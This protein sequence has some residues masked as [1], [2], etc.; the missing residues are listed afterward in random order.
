MSTMFNMSHTYKELPEVF[1]SEAEVREMPDPKMILFNDKLAEVLGLSAR[2][3]DFLDVLAGKGLETSPIA[4]AYA[5]HQF[6]QFT[7]LGDGRA[8]LLGEH[9]TK[10]GVRYDIQLKGTGRTEFS[11]MGDGLAPVGPMIREY[12]ISEALHA[13][14]VPTNRSLAVMTTGDTAEREASY[15]AAVLARVAS[16]HLRVG[17]FEYAARLSVEHVKS[18]ADYSIERHYPN[19]KDNE[20]KYLLFLESVAHAQSYLISEW[21]GIGFIHGVMNTDNMTISGESIDFGPC[22]FMDSYDQDALFSS[23]DAQGRYRYRNQ[24]AIGQWNLSKLAEALIPLIDEDEEKAKQ[25]AEDVLQKYRDLYQA[26]WLKKQANKLGIISLEESDVD[27]ILEWLNILE[28][29]QADYTLSFR[30]LTNNEISKLPFKDDEQF[31]E[32]FKSWQDTL[33]DKTETME[34]VYTLMKAVNPAVIPRN[35]IVNQA[36]DDAVNHEDYSK[37]HELVETLKTPYVDGHD[38]RF[39]TPPEPG[40]E[41]KHTFCGT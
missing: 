30:N 38:S 4:L 11:R 36:I 31:K 5:G 6:G 14:G 23:I 25:K 22:A 8:V 3:D 32:W 1:W 20:D 26:Y 41:V 28:V 18:L 2:S 35:H 40:E 10:D 37:V 17:T 27:L 13:L 39:T 9:V 24:P 12:I 29:H 15:P 16:S 7:M 33:N 19:L 34:E 21:M